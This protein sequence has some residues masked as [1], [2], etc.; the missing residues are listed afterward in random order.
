MKKRVIISIMPHLKGGGVEKVV[1]A[2]SE[3]LNKFED[4]EVHIITIKPF[5]NL[6]PLT[7][8]VKVHAINLD[9]RNK[10]KQRISNKKKC[11]LITEYINKN[12]TNYEPD[13]VLCHQETVSKIMQY[14]QYKAI[15]HVVHSNLS[16][17][18]LAN[19]KGLT[20]IL[21]VLKVHR[22]YKNVNVICV[23]KG[24]ADD[25][26]N[27]F[28]IYDARVIYNAI[29]VERLR[30]LAHEHFDLPKKPYFI[31]V[32]NFTVAKRQ[33]RLV[34]AYI[35]SGIQD[36]DLVM[37]GEHTKLTETVKYLLLKNPAIA[38]RIHLPGFVSN[39][40]PWIANSKGF[41]L[42]S[43]YE[44]L[45]T[46]LL[47]SIA[48]GIPTISTDCKS[49]PREIF[50]ENYKQCLSEVNASSLRDKILELYNSPK[51]FSVPLREE[52]SLNFMSRQYYKLIKQH[53]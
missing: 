1:S 45:P 46:V 34:H 47:E 33:D 26:K 40:Y 48:L 31:H 36:V 7:K 16:H 50:G 37:L 13:L 49:G 24:V 9:I 23:S 53:K 28:G 39:P 38:K 21:R 5:E 3:G 27:T 14:S 25:L 44:G 15:Y 42:A 8:E 18:R 6:T 35:E 22:L 12:I 29:D 52:F 11:R 10:L 30:I 2:L 43:D 4:C 19:S 32:G 41:I 20:R 51:D 17:D